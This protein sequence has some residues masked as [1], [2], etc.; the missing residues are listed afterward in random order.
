[1]EEVREGEDLAEDGRF[2]VLFRKGMIDAD[3]GLLRYN[4]IRE[5]MNYIDNK[6]AK[7]ESIKIL[8]TKVNRE[9]RLRGLR[10]KRLYIRKASNRDREAE[11]CI[12]TTSRL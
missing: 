10:D 4:S 5:L 1:M 12:C 6:D 3:P 7:I 8:I 9:L 11:N 2:N